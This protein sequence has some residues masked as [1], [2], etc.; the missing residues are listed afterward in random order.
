MISKLIS[1]NKFKLHKH[2]GRKNLS[3]S[4]KRMIARKDLPHPIAQA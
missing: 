4:I 2:K 3:L 1:I